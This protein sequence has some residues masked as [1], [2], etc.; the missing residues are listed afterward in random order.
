MRIPLATIYDAKALQLFGHKSYIVR[1][2][3][4]SL[5][6]ILDLESASLYHFIFKFF[7]RSRNDV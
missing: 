3:R 7:S 4:R 6:E 5:A 1:G 2:L